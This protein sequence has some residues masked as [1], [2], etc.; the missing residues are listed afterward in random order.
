[1]F[2]SKGTTKMNI[3]AV[4]LLEA[5][6]QVEKAGG[7]VH[8]IVCDGVLTNRSLWKQ[9]GI[10]GD[11]NN[12]KFCF[13]NPYDESRVIYA[14]SDAPHLIKCIRNRLEQNKILRVNIIYIIYQIVEKVRSS[15]VPVFQVLICKLFLISNKL[16]NE[17]CKVLNYVYSH[18]IMYRQTAEQ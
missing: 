10:S 13:Q 9:F 1:M 17:F 15:I 16:K 18:F 3:L 8:G 7:K 14:F 4:L 6:L 5:I 2:G 11:V 12:C